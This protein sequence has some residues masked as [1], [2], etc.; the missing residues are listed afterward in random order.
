MLVFTYS[1]SK[2][3]IQKE[4]IV[5]I[6]NNENFIWANTIEIHIIDKLLVST[7]LNYYTKSQRER[8]LHKI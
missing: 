3:S 7:T 6:G 8:F 5:K 4:N 1:D 2:K